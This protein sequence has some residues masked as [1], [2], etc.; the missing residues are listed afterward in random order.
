MADTRQLTPFGAAAMGAVF[1]AAGVFPILVGAGVI[2]RG[3]ADAPAWVIGAAGA[4]FVCAG[5]AVLL[6]YGIA[7]GVGPDND[8]RPGTPTSIRVANLILG[9]TI[10]GLMT[11]VAG[12]IAFGRGSRHF[13]T[14]LIVPFLPVSRTWA[15]GEWPGRVAFGTGSVL[16]AAMFVACAVSG[17]R[18]IAQSRRGRS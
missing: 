4:M 3:D 12:W 6:D 15:S 11:V 18:R 2:P 1:I 13:T 14:T 9:L 16:M 10:V 5:L 8:L 7:G 17:V